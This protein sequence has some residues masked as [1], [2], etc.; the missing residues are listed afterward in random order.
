M[1]HTSSPAPSAGACRD[2]L[3]ASPFRTAL[4]PSSRC[5]AAPARRTPAAPPRSVPDSKG[6]SFV[7]HPEELAPHQFPQA[8]GLPEHQAQR[9]EPLDLA[10]PAAAVELGLTERDSNPVWAEPGA[11]RNIVIAVDT[12]IVS[13]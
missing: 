10:Q 13:I 2:L 11:K 3:A 4:R 12:S 5:N 8:L 7:S 6:H 9:A 1:V